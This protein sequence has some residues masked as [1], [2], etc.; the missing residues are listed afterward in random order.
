MKRTNLRKI[1]AVLALILALSAFAGCAQKP[2]E[3]VKSETPAET[4]TAEPTKEPV[5]DPTE[6]PTE[7]PTP[8]PTE[9]PTPAPTPTPLKFNITEI[10]A[11]KE[12][13]PYVDG[14]AGGGDGWKFY[15]SDEAEVPNMYFKEGKLVLENVLADTFLQ[16]RLSPSSEAVERTTAEILDN[17]YAIGFYVENNNPD[18]VGVTYFGEFIYTFT[19][20]D[21]GEDETSA[22]QAVFYQTMFD[23]IECYLV[24]LEGNATPC[25]EFETD[26][27]ARTGCGLATIPGNFKGYYI[28]ALDS[29]G[30]YTCYYGQW[31]VHS[32]DDCG[33]GAYR[34][35][36][37]VANL[38]F[39]L[40]ANEES[41]GA[42]Y[43]IGDYVL[44]NKAN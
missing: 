27:S 35:G 16:F 9:V 13:K 6:V 17:T 19:R 31:N 25:E 24:D 41:D 38:G 7:A 20:S 33:R 37:S 15:P 22:H 12:D 29:I 26:G 14:T 8:E 34:K 30:G 21:T 39:S 3:P 5:Q 23:D 42:T 43:V 40:F 18:P 44:A 2:E 28:V 36:S 11:F 1:A 10:G 32:Q 4:K